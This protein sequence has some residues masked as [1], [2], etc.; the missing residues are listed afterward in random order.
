MTWTSGTRQYLTILTGGGPAEDS[1]GR[2]DEAREHLRRAAELT[3]NT[4][5]QDA[6]LA[7]G[8]AVG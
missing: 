3:A 4:R 7:R 5:E 1:L 8:A 2:L 6:L